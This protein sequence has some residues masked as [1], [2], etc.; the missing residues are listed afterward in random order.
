ML[1]RFNYKKANGDISS[2]IVHELSIVDGDKLLCV[3]LTTANVSDRALY[4]DILADIRRDY[5]SAI[6]DAG[7]GNNF[8]TFLLKGIS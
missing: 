1:K 6:K 8:R 5:I 3:D 4:D 7:L 2:R